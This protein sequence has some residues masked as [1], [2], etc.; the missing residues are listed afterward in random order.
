MHSFLPSTQIQEELYHEGAAAGSSADGSRPPAG[1]RLLRVVLRLAFPSASAADC[2]SR[3][4]ELLRAGV[5]ATAGVE[6]GAVSIERIAAPSAARR[7]PHL[8]ITLHV[9]V[10]PHV[11]KAAALARAVNGE[12]SSEG[13]GGSGSTAEQQVPTEQQPP[14]SAP[15]AAAAASEAS[16]RVE[17]LVAALGGQP[18]VA[19]LGRP[20]PAHCSADVEDVTPGAPDAVGGGLGGHACCV[21]WPPHLSLWHTR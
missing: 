11:L 13:S 12:G 17:Q 14:S 19:V 6:P 1:Q 15:G 21:D 2:S 10:G 5:A 4:R 3:A 7:Q 16:P 20:D 18:L 9:S 8:A